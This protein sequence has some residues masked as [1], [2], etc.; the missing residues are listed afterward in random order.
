MA[1]PPSAALSTSSCPSRQKTSDRRPRPPN[2]RWPARPGRSAPDTPC[3]DPAAI[4]A[5]SPHSRAAPWTVDRG[6]QPAG[7][8]GPSPGGRLDQ[9]GRHRRG[10][11]HQVRRRWAGGRSGGDRPAQPSPAA[12]GFLTHNPTDCYCWSP[13][14]RSTNDSTRPVGSNDLSYPWSARGPLLEQKPIAWG[15]VREHDSI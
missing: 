1:Y 11:P 10:R 4:P 12:L 3:G 15:A 6:S 5:T 2:P 14:H 13:K 7:L 8:V 9:P